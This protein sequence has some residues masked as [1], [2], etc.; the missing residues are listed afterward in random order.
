MNEKTR[1]SGHIC[2]IS[3]S[4]YPQDTRLAQQATILLRHGIGLDILCLSDKGQPDIEVHG[5]LTV[6]RLMKSPYKHNF[7]TY[8]VTTASFG[9]L[10][11]VN[12]AMLS[13]KNNYKVIV[14]HTLPEFLVFIGLFHRLSG[15][16]IIL[17]GRD[18]TVE[19]ISSRW[20]TKASGMLLY[21]AALIERICTTFCNEVITA[22]PGFKRQLVKRGVPENKI[23]VLVNT[24]DTE[25]FKYDE[26]RA[27]APILRGARFIYHGTVSPRFGIIVAVEAMPEVLAR[28][29]ESNLFVFGF[30]DKTYRGQIEK[31]IRSLSLEKNV[32]LR[33]P[34]Q[35]VD[36]YREILTMDIGVV[37]YLSDNFMNLALSTKTFEYVASGLP[38]VASRLRSAEEMYSTNALQFA[39]PGNPRDFARKI[40]EFCKDPQLRQNKR[41]QAFKEFQRHSTDVI[42]R[43]YIN[44]I[45]KYLG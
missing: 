42:G 15:K 18:L 9:I 13:M 17:D 31:A 28:I 27:F 35:L 1:Q 12:L 19:L 6:R 41:C 45:N 30:Y 32:F 16:A 2:I 11:F 40:I 14:V 24:A 4:L 43:S 37:P 23:T 34:L 8:L 22:S 25:I 36:I 21:C 3:K 26:N 38:V 7:A 33:D 5:T 29:P 44:L 39:E 10:S 20:K